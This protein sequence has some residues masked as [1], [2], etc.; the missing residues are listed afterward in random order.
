MVNVDI[1][2][3][4]INLVVSLFIIADSL[5]FLFS[6]FFFFFLIITITG[7][8][9]GIQ[10]TPIQIVLARFQIQPMV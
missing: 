9:I 4:F 10:Q 8:T 3:L 6:S 2:S 1:Q 5:P 7:G